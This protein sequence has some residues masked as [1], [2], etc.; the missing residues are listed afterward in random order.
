MDPVLERI[1]ECV[2]VNWPRIILDG[3]AMSAMFNAA[4]LLGFTLWPQEYSVMF[5]KEIK[6]AAAPYV[7]KKDV[8]K[9][10]LFLYGLY[11]ALFLYWAISAQLAGTKGFWPLFWTGYVE[12]TFVSVSDF[13][14]LD[15]WLPQKVR[16]RIKG[17]EHCKAWDRKEWLMKLAIP[18]HALG[19]TFLV[20]PIA[21]LIV[22]GIAVLFAAV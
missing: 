12:M 3:I 5:P 11:L 10:K 9:M 16:N 2:P 15:L 8:R 21:G 6:E 14:I 4:V 17:A 7:N 22:A 20:C 19:W 1:K 18:E 13:L